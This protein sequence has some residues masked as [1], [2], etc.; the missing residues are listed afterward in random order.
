VALGMTLF[1][2]VPIRRLVHQLSVPVKYLGRT[3]Q[4]VR[5]RGAS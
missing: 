4:V 2:N 3:S 1:V 5:Q